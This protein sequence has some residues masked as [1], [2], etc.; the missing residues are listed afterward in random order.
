MP[1]I[2]NELRDHTIYA[3]CYPDKE[4]Y[5]YVGVSKLLDERYQQHVGAKTGNMEKDLIIRAIKSKDKL[6]RLV[7]LEDNLTEDEAYKSE[8]GWIKRLSKTGHKL[9]N[10]T[11]GGKY[12]HSVRL[13]NRI[14]KRRKYKRK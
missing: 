3:L 14:K 13:Y 7:I 8:S 4:K 5:F 10:R 2:D 9:T 11:E 1:I 12:P 6:P